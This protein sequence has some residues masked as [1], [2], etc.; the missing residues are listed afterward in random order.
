MHSDKGTVFLM[1]PAA[2]TSPRWAS[3]RDNR[4]CTAG[5][6]SGR[7]YNSESVNECYHILHSDAQLNWKIYSNKNEDSWY[8][9]IAS[10]PKNMI[11]LTITAENVNEVS[12][13]FGFH[14][15][16]LVL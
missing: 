10:C 4:A 14:A 13:I 8:S 7:V 15:C 9:A 3:Y 11:C 5:H 12:F 2:S 1:W 16:F 6:G